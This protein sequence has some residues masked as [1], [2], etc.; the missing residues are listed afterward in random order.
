MEFHEES[1]DLTGK[2]VVVVPKVTS[3]KLERQMNVKRD[4]K[5]Q[6]KKAMKLSKTE[7][8]QNNS[9]YIGDHTEPQPAQ[10]IIQSFVKRSEKN[11]PYDIYDN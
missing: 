6:A 8:D 10:R 2:V 7:M 3:E 11:N 1:M 4:L 9:F 5:P